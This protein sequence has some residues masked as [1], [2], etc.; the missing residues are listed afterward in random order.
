MLY[1]FFLEITELKLINLG[2]LNLQGYK[3][4][5]EYLFASI[6][7]FF[8]DIREDFQYPQDMST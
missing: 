6:K 2:F 1:T 7:F 5:Q 3:T 4:C 8:F